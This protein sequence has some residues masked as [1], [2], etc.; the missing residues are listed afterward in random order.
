LS[1]LQLCHQYILNC[2][3]DLD[4]ADKSAA[5]KERPCVIQWGGP[6]CPPFGETDV[7]RS[8]AKP[9]NRATEELTCR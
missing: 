2:E 6:P 7:A 1:I 3:C 8:W 4:L 9:Y 5:N